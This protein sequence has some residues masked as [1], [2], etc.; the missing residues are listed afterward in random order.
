R[1]GGVS[2]KAALSGRCAPYC[3]VGVCGSVSRITRGRRRAHL[4]RATLDSI[5]LSVNQVASATAE[6]LEQRRINRGGAAAGDLLG[7]LRRGQRGLTL[8][9]LL[10][11]ELSTLAAAKKGGLG[12]GIMQPQRTLQK[13]SSWSELSL[14]TWSVR[15]ERS[16]RCLARRRA[17]SALDDLVTLAGERKEQGCRIRT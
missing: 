11:L 5:A 7:A 6:D 1:H 16:A 9:R 15:N 4:A 2:S 10:I 12:A 8:E 17:A 14:P 13:S 3:H